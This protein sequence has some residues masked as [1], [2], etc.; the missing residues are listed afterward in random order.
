MRADKNGQLPPRVVITGFMAAGKTTVARAL[1]RL[2]D[3]SVIDLDRSVTTIEGR[4]PRDLID[5]KGEEYFR[6]A[7]TRA[8]Q[9][10]LELGT[11]RIIATGGGTWTLERNRT[12]I[13]KSGCLSVWLDA[14]FELC[15]QRIEA[16]GDT[17][18]LARSR[19]SARRLYDERLAAYALAKFHLR[20]SEDSTAEELARE[21]E[22][23]LLA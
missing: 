2:L 15:W 6:E 3:D 1:A 13:H 4:T 9:C 11:A 5:E 21:I 20:V 7:E 18:P 8:L 16:A 10:A 14:P 12:L 17:R 19:E 23:V 22:A